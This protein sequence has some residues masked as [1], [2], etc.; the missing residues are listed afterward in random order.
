MNAAGSAPAF[1]VGRRDPV[2]P[3]VRPAP[4]WTAASPARPRWPRGASG[5]RKA[6]NGDA[7]RN[8]LVQPHQRHARASRSR[9]ISASGK[10]EVFGAEGDVLVHRF[11]KQLVFRI[12]KHQSHRRGESACR[13]TSASLARSDAVYKH[14]CPL[15]ARSS[16]FKCAISV[17]LPLPVCPITPINSPSLDRQGHVVQ[18]LRFKGR[19]RACIYALRCFTSTGTVPPPF[20]RPSVYRRADG[21]TPASRRCLRQLQSFRARPAPTRSTSSTLGEHLQRRALQADAARVH[22]Q[23]AVGAAPPLP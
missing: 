6:S 22:H 19:A 18:R 16:A 20:L 5:R 15:V 8:A 11:L 2:L 3:P 23:H 13:F 7:L 12:L 10:A 9:L 17:D 4:V 14:T 1:R 21:S